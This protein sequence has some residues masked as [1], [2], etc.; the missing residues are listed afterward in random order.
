MNKIVEVKKIPKKTF[1]L[2][3]AACRGKCVYCNQN[4]ITG[5]QEIISLDKVANELSFLET[6]HEVCFFGGSFCRFPKETVFAYLDAV[7][8][9]APDGSTIRFST[10]PCDLDEESFRHRIK[11]YP[12][13]CVEFGIQSMD[14]TTLAV[15]RRVQDPTTILKSLEV[16][17]SEKIPLGVQLMAGLPGQTKESSLADLEKLAKVKGNELWDLRLYPCLVISGTVLEK[18]YN[19]SS[20]TPLSL[21]QAIDWGAD[22]LNRALELGFNPIRIGL[23]ETDSLATSVI[24]GP[25]HPAL[26]ELIEGIAL[27]RRLARLNKV[28]W[29]V[30]K[31]DISKLTGHDNFGFK[32]LARL[33]MQSLENTKKD[34]TFI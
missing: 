23:Q 25:H 1:F 20:Y 5:V 14:E 3:F 33:T 15:T 31:K 18:M 7:K 26:G 19:V 27:A 12:L 16:L 4:A 10:Y 34:V 11:T 32:E 9:C 2:P 29:I 6:P 13:S 22:F 28:K 21:E 17:K 8:D 30:H 24:A